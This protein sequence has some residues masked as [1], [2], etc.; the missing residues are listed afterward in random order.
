MF[1]KFVPGTGDWVMMLAG[2]MAFLSGPPARR[3]KVE[4]NSVP[5]PSKHRLPLYAAPSDF[6]PHGAWDA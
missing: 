2:L 5:C 3:T 1:M 6:G 4:K